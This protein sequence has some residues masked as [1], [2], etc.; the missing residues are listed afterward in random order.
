MKRGE[1]R[2]FLSAGTNDVHN[3]MALCKACHSR[4]TLEA[5]KNNRE[6]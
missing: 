5:N 2:A 6:A 4:I 1:R 3:L